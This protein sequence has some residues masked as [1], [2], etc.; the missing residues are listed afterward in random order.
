MGYVVVL[1]ISIPIPFCNMHECL[2]IRAIGTVQCTW[3]IYDGSKY[4]VKAK[5]LKW[6][7]NS[8]LFS[9]SYLGMFKDAFK[10]STAAYSKCICIRQRK[11]V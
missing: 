1:V 11:L 10:T 7:F 2:C 6:A 4:P 9:L 5:I 8:F 3:C